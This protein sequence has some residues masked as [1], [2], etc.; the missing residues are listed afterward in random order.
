[1]TQFKWRLCF[2]SI[3]LYLFVMSMVVAYNILSILYGFGV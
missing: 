1:M 2:G 3:F